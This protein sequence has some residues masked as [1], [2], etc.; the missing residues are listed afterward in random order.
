M[1]KYIAAG[2]V[3]TVGRL[4]LAVLADFTWFEGKELGGC[5]FGGMLNEYREGKEGVWTKYGD[6]TDLEKYRDILKTR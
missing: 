4:V 6:C 3:L 2:V 5:L 1:Q